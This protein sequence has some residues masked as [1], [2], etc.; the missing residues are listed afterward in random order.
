MGETQEERIMQFLEENEE[1]VVGLREGSIL[2]VRDAAVVLKD[3]PPHA[4]SGEVR[5]PSR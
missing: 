2:L 1:T 5:N 3:R 4:Y